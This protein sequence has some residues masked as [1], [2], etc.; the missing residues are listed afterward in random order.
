MIYQRYILLS[1]K[2]ITVEQERIQKND[3][4]YKW[5]LYEGDN[6]VQKGNIHNAIFQYREAQKFQPHE[7][8][9]RHKLAKALILA[10]EKDYD[11]SE[12]SAMF[13]KELK[14]LRDKYP[15]DETLRQITEGYFIP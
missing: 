14:K 6:W 4:L 1:P 11:D 12:Q 10:L 9:G 8:T 13:R 3:S 15:M 7:L 2:E 5:Y